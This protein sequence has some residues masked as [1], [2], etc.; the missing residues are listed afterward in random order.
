MRSAVVILCVLVGCTADIVDDDLGSQIEA[1]S[2]PL[3]VSG[4]TW[5][6]IKTQSIMYNSVACMTHRLAGS[7]KPS[8]GNFC[9]FPPGVEC[10]VVAP[11]FGGEALFFNEG[12]RIYIEPLPLPSPNGAAF[13][14]S[15]RQVVKSINRHTIAYTSLNGKHSSCS[16]DRVSGRAIW[17]GEF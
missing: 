12:D 17:E 14:A 13:L 6:G 11:W 2:E 5:N 9:E 10:R 15:W 4:M 8:A 3:T 16:V 1:A 7:V